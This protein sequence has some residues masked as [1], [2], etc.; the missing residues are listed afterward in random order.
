MVNSAYIYPVTG[1]LNEGYRFVTDYGV[2]YRVYFMDDYSIWDTGAYQFIIA[3]ENKRKSP[4]DP[5][6]KETVFHLIEEFFAANPSILLYVCET[7]DGK[8]SMRN[9]LF[10]RW[11]KEY[12]QRE[13]Y[14]VEHVVIEAEGICH[15]AAIIVQQS[16]TRLNEII[17]EFHDAIDEL[18]KPE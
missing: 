1:D 18:Q 2:V 14:Y 13:R 6:V 12:G 15:Y 4:N 10:L 11:L 9:R 17:S 16:N 3:N 8:E 5:K 7:G